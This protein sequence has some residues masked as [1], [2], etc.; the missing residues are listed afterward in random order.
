MRKAL[1]RHEN[2]SPSSGRV[3]SAIARSDKFGPE[4]DREREREE[5]RRNKSRAKA[6]GTSKCKCKCKYKR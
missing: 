6:K 4:G 5:L 1:F 2:K 3:I